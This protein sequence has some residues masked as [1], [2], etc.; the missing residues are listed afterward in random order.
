[1]C[2]GTSGH[3]GLTLPATS[4]EGA[5]GGAD[6]TL[7]DAS[8]ADAGWFDVAI[9]YADRAI[10]DVGAAAP[11]GDGGASAE[12]GHAWPDCPDFV[13]VDRLGRPAKPGQQVN[14]VRPASVDDA[15]NPLLTDAGV[16]VLA[17]DGSACATYGWFG[18]PAIDS[19][20]TAQSSDNFADFPP[21][22]WCLGAGNASAGPQIGVSRYDLCMALYQCIQRTGCAADPNNTSKCLC[23]DSPSTQCDAGGPCANE[24]LASIESLSDSTSLFNA[25]Y[26]YA[27]PGTPEPGTCGRTL[28]SVYLLGLSNGCLGDGGP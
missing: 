23:G 28:N 11:P 13:P 18:S 2:G 6:A 27:S 25:L 20:V 8:G 19:C 15:G 17:P 26:N 21:C 4:A 22:N 7:D 1:M 12:A 16:V 24:E 10:P 5:D 3:E 9:T 14:Q